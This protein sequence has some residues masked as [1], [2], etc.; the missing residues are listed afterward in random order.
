[1]LELASLALWRCSLVNG[2]QGTVLSN[3]I[4]AFILDG[5]ADIE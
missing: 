1:M 4:G 3:E 5:R 2:K